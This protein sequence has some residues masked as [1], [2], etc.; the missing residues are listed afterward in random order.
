LQHG[1]QH[2]ICAQLAAVVFSHCDEGRRQNLFWVS[3][4]DSRPVIGVRNRRPDVVI[5]ALW[6]E[7]PIVRVI[8]ASPS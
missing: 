5:L 1:V 3:G 4:D 7:A 8:L 6:F 2:K